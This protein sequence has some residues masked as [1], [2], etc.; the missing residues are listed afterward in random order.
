MNTNHS[1]ITVYAFILTHD[2][3]CLLDFYDPLKTGKGCFP[4]LSINPKISCLSAMRNFL[5]NQYQLSFPKFLGAHSDAHR[6]ILVF[7]MD[8]RLEI[9]NKLQPVSLAKAI[10]H[11]IE[12]E[13]QPFAWRAYEKVMLKGFVLPHYN[14]EIWP[15]GHSNDEANYLGALVVSG[16]KTATSSLLWSYEFEEEPLPKVGVISIIR[17]QEGD[18]IAVI[19]TTK[20]TK[21]PFNKVTKEFASEEGEGDFSLEHWRQVHWEFFAKE[22]DVMDLEPEETMPVVCENFRVL[23]KILPW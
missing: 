22:C 5:N 20:V 15:F 17:D 4:T 8:E 19:E 13:L 21:I 9:K 1:S 16:E 10:Q 3:K 18:A 2:H 14:I 7:R 11:F 23:H 6:R 12:P